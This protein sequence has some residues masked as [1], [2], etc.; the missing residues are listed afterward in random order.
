[1]EKS[2]IGPN[3][4]ARNKIILRLMPIYLLELRLTRGSNQK[5]V[6]FGMKSLDI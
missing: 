5:S 6:R 2:V 1:M 3:I 4:P